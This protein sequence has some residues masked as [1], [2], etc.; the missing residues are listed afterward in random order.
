MACHISIR[1]FYLLLV[2]VWTKN[3]DS[4]GFCSNHVNIRKHR[5]SMSMNEK[6]IGIILVDHG[7][8]RSDAN[9]ML[10]QIAQKYKAFT[11]FSIVEP[12]HMELV[13]PSISTGK[14]VV[15]DIPSL[16]TDAARLHNGVTFTIT[17]P[18]GVQKSEKSMDVET[19][20]V[21]KFY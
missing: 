6:L 17:E 1:L 15:E 13:E 9:D 2:C 12:A 3:A 14:H 10:I 20:F 21:D 5:L 4:F 16:M 8:R 18:L 11:E 19:N 7:S